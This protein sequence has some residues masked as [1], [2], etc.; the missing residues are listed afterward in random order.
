M[1]TTVQR[2][3]TID[4]LKI[5]LTVGIV[6]LHAE[7]RNELGN[8]Y[9]FDIFNRTVTGVMKVCVPLFFVLSGFLYF[10]NTPS[11][12]DLRFFWKKLRRRLYSLLLPYLFANA[13]AF[14]VYWAAYRWAPQ[15]MSGFLGDNWKNPL[16][17]FWTG[18]V[19]IS[20]W[21]IRDL[22]IAVLF[23]PLTWL[24]VRYAR[25]WG[26][27]ALAVVCH[28][29]GMRPWY[30]LYFVLGAWLALWHASWVTAADTLLLRCR[31]PAAP[32]SGQAWCFFIYLYHYLF[33]LTLKKALPQWLHPDGFWGLLG[34]YLS[35]VLLTL[36]FLTGVFFLLK[37][38]LPRLLNVLTGGKR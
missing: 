7:L 27:L 17:I 37:K 36:A 24:L 8:S 5:L 11:Q 29:W 13:V 33:T 38:T 16:F 22:L 26:V 31:I 2:Y 10:R 23:A 3:Q 4:L 30:N 15:S 19:N 20:L 21:F 28:C 35:V 34:V 1:G 9:A 6:F 25:I 12:P 32:A 14:L 18:P